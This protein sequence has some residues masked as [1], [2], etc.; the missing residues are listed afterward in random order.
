MKKLLTRNYL[1][2]ITLAVFALFSLALI[3][4]PQVR[5]ADLTSASLSLS[6]PRPSQTS[7]TYDFE[8]SNVTTQSIRCIQL[9]FATTSTGSTVPTG[10]DTT[11]A[12]LSGSSDYVPTP[13]S[14]TV[15]PAVN[16]YIEITNATG[17][18]PASST[19]RNVI[20]TGITNSSTVD[21][22]FFLQ[23]KTYSQDD[24]STGLRD[25][26]TV[27]FINTSGQSVS[28]SVDPSLSFTVAG[29]ASGSSCN[30]ATTNATTT[31][32]T[33]PFGT[34][35]TTTNGIAAQDLTV[36][37]NAS[38]GYTT[39][40]RYTGAPSNGTDTIND[41]SGSNATPSSFS[42]AGTE[43]FGYTTNDA[44]LGTGTADR[45]TNPANQWA[46]FT[47]T[48]AE[49]AFDSGAVSSQVTCV[50]YQV[51]ISGATPAGAYTTTVIHTTTPTY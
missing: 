26:V 22:N 39:Y 4:L 19:D 36:S 51:G 25:S 2:K 6:D 17:E 3:A 21:T 11:S 9:Q 20:L 48:N 5:A 47:T 41:H 35:T 43:A 33:V 10:M 24:C 15:A 44:T 14:W 46:A 13:G 7:V 28:L 8:A 49:I 12:A 1:A 38:G 27:A 32:T 34:I 31:A 29:K 18:T 45:F 40:T 23:F 37:T 16:G 50:G 30:G 42:A